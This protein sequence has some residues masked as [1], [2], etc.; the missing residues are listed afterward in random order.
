LKQ[1]DPGLRLRFPSDVKEWIER[2]AKKNMRSQNAEIVFRLRR[3]M[4]KGNARTAGTEGR[5]GGGETLAG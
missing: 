4:E 3:D 1:T 5:D 2:E